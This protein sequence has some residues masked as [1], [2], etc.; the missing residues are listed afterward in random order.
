VLPRRRPNRTAS[1]F[2][3]YSEA[4]E[5]PA[6]GEQFGGSPHRTGGRPMGYTFPEK[7]ECPG[8]PDKHVPG[9]HNGAALGM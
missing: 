4:P 6:G 2:V 1:A 3:G 5:A 8:T 7:Q 9:L